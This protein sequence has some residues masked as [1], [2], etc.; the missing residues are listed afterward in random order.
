VVSG[1]IIADAMVG[2]AED[3]QSGD[4]R[5]ICGASTSQIVKWNTIR[6]GNII[7]VRPSEFG[8]AYAIRRDAIGKY[9]PTQKA[10]IGRIY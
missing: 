4:D 3:K 7:I 6:A 9:V 10:N 8:G 1:G 2:Q 5:E